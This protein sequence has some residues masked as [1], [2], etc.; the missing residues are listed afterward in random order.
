MNYQTA[1]S[2]IETQLRDYLGGRKAVIGISGGI[3]SAVVAAL[4]GEAIGKERVLGVSMPYGNQ[5]TED[6][7]LVIRHLGINSREVNIKGIVDNFNFLNLDRLSKGNLMARA[8]MC[9]LY[10]F[11][12]QLEGL[13]IGTSNKSEIEIGYF[14]KNGDG[15]VDI[16][17]LG[18]L[19][20]TEVFE[21]AKIIRLPKKT[22][23]N[24]PSAGLW[25]GQTDEN[26]FGMTYQELDAV[27]KGEINSGEIYEKVQKLIKAT[28]HKRKMPPIFK[29]KR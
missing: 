25:E 3:D 18:D 10:A 6:T 12:N 17:P 14:T 4:C 1:I 7:N 27:L 21:V 20:K 5:N 28:E 23:D 11:A 15:G 2:D 8:R 9:V 26:D 13:V 16:E 24:K 19:Y 29:V 22:I